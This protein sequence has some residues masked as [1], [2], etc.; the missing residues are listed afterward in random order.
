MFI[1]IF[2]QRKRKIFSELSL[3]ALQLVLEKELTLS[4][5]EGPVNEKN[6]IFSMEILEWGKRDATDN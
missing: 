3:P 6:C 4:T 1:F 2:I 5:V